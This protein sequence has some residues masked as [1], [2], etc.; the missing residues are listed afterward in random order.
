MG[1]W[2]KVITAEALPEVPAA[3]IVEI[4]AM[5]PEFDTAGDHA[6]PDWAGI[7]GITDEAAGTETKKYLLVSYFITKLLVYPD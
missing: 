7:P 1:P 4:T 2:A 5:T 6:V 3:L